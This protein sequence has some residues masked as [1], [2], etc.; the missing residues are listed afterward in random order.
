MVETEERIFS[1]SRDIQTEKLLYIIDSEEDI[2]NFAKRY[3]EKHIKQLT[4]KTFS[5]SGEAIDAARHKVPDLV[6]TD[7]RRTEDPIST[8]LFLTLLRFNFLQKKPKLFLF[9][10]YR[11][12]YK[13]VSH[14]VDGYQAKPC[15]LEEFGRKVIGLL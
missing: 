4:I 14:L 12:G 13:R 10:G 1:V 8:D 2:R 9:S 3:F 7:Y 6:I 5:T 15:E 11:T